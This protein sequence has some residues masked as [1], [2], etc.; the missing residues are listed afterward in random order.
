M[1]EAER[2]GGMNEDR[3]KERV[4]RL[5]ARLLET[6]RACAQQHAALGK[7]GD[8]LKEAKD[9]YSE[10]EA[11]ALIRRLDGVVKPYEE[12]LTRWNMAAWALQEQ[13]SL[14]PPAEEGT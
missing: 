3:W 7:L 8:I 11:W 5:E 9:D 1:V 14:K 10:V 2:S 4:E 12:F 6:C 13:G